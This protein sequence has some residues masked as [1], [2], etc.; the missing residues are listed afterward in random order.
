MTESRQRGQRGAGTL[1]KTVANGREQWCAAMSV[2][3]ANG[4][5]VKVRG[6]G[7]SPTQAVERRTANLQKR[8]G[9]SGVESQARSPRLSEYVS[10]W[11]DQIGDDEQTA[12]S[13]KRNR[14]NLEQHVLPY[15]DKPLLTI[16][17]QDVQ[18][19]FK[20][21]LP[22]RGRTP[23][24]I[25]NAYASLRT[26]F[27]YA[28]RMESIPSDH[29]PLRP[30]DV[31]KPI[32]AVREADDQFV[33]RRLSVSKRML[34]EI[35][36]PKNEHYRLLPRFLL[37]FLGLRRAEL[38]GLEWSCVHNLDSRNKAYIEVKQ[39]LMR[40][41][42]TGKWTIERRT[43]N[44]KPRK[45]PLPE[46]MRLALRDAKKSRIETQEEWANDL[47]FLTDN[48]K[49]VTY[50]QYAKDWNDALTNYLKENA[51]DPTYRFR[52][53]AMRRLTVNFLLDAGQPIQ[54]VRRILGHQTI[55]MTEYYHSVTQASQRTAVEALEEAIKAGEK[56]GKTMPDVVND[57]TS[58]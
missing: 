23:S 20:R 55:D 18:T 2:K 56:R 27:N 12:T 14:R 39:Q 38:L 43:K 29:D 17:T 42:D 46:M 16:T 8:L 32:P 41:E 58:V 50:N 13:R 48:G 9:G 45:V 24:S 11:L 10:M 3:D 5:T 30:V 6:F 40:D 52:P 44:R 54:A 53:H 1:F 35:S 49:H 47:V 22:D 4:K 57:E 33:E 25:Y 31:R 51:Q 21:T 26:L 36:D 37:M 15:L 28:R 7:A 19:L 34:K